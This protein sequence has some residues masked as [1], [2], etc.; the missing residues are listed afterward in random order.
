M[1][2]YYVTYRVDARY[3]AEVKGK[4]LDDAMAKANEMFSEADFG[5]AQDIDGEAI[6]VENEDGDFI[7]E[8]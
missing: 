6:I 2:T 1:K 7:W 5:E 8:R 3:V 4:D